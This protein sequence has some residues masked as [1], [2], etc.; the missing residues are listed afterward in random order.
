VPRTP[1]FLD[2]ATEDAEAAARW[3]AV[4]LEQDL[5]TEYQRFLQENNRGRS[6]SD[7]RTAA[8]A[9]DRWGSID[10]RIFASKLP[11]TGHPVSAP[12]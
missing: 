9:R 6:N 1:E 11:V 8:T 10:L 7:G 2:E 12:R 3:Y 5:E 4:V